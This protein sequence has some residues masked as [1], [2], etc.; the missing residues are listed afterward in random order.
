MFR[1]W[2]KLY[3]NNKIITDMVVENNAPSLSK[4]DKIQDAVEEIC[5]ALDMSKPLWLLN[6]TE[7]MPVYNKTSFHQ[8]HFMESIDF[9]Y[10]EIEIIE[11]DK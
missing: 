5:Y 2:G 10:F 6:N 4:E 11:E 8:D 3:K 1:L 9:D 7:E